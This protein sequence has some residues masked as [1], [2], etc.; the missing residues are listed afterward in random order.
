MGGFTAFI[1]RLVCT[2]HDYRSLIGGGGARG[3]SSTSSFQE[4][5]NKAQRSIAVNKAFARLARW[6]L[7]LATWG[8]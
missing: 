4:R 6:E 1:A 5:Q 3:T 7:E 2:L 8:C